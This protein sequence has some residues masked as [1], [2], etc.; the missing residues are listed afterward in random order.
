MVKALVALTYRI[1]KVATAWKF[2][3]AYC[4]YSSHWVI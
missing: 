1:S 4:C 3:G 2:F